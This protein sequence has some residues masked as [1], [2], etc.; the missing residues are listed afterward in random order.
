MDPKKLSQPVPPAAK[1]SPVPAA[2]KKL[3][4][5]KKEIEKKEIKKDLK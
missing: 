1:V 5:E 3:L 2:E 4:P